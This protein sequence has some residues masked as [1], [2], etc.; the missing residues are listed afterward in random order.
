MN[1]R[2]FLEGSGALA[3]AAISST[4]KSYAQILGSNEKVGLGIIGV[5]RRGR[6]VGGAFLEDKRTRL[7]AI[8]D[9]YDVTRLRVLAQLPPELPEPTS[10]N[11]YEDLLTHKEVEAVLIA[12]PDHLHVTIAAAAL[13]KG[14]H[15]YLEKPT[16]H[17]WREKDEL[18]RAAQ[19]SKGLLQCGMQQRSGTHYQKVKQEFFDNGTL[20]E[21]VQVRAVWHDFPW[22]C[23]Q[24]PEA[25]KPVGLDWERFL[26]PA[27]HV[28]YET[29]R[30][31]SWR[32][33]HDYGNGLLADILTH[34]VDVAQWMLSDKSPKSAYA[35]GGIYSLRDQRDNPDT[36]SAI[37]KYDKWNLNF[38][39]SV[40]PLRNNR[41]SVLFEGTKGNLELAR[42]GYLFTPR[43]GEAVRVDTKQDLE[44][45]HTKN[46]LDAIT[47]GVSLNAPLDAGLA[48]SVPVL[49]AVKSYWSSAAV[50]SLDEHAAH[51]AGKR[52]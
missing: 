46:F 27:P 34:W 39:S 40:L 9:T 12:A 29:V 18:I 38:E 26:G 14:K 44:A 19:Q 17:R 5:G 16:L 3:A 11:A 52:S 28:P 6:I 33:F 43:A 31:D 20:G 36:V 30:Y 32:Y 42:D 35:T 7:I 49:M 47:N 37:V 25:P 10:F 24:V 22:Q 21:V 51:N 4:A 2:R 48:A 45:A 13:E 41:P 15:V 1:R 50:T 23:R 8:A